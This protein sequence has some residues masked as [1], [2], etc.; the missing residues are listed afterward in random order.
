MDALDN[1]DYCFVPA[2]IDVK[3]AK[4]GLPA[5]IHENYAGLAGCTKHT[6]AGSLAPR[7][8]EEWDYHARIAAEVVGG[9]EELRK[10]PIIRSIAIAIGPMQ[11]PKQACWNILGPAKHG[12]PVQGQAMTMMTANAPS[13][14]AGNISHQYAANLATLAL[15]Q[16]V[17]PGMTFLPMS[18]AGRLSNFG[19]VLETVPD[20]MLSSAARC[21]LIQERL[22]LPV[23]SAPIGTSHSKIPDVQFAYE[24]ALVTMSLVLSG[25]N[26][27]LS[28]LHNFDYF[29]A[30]TF[31]MGNEFAGYMKNMHAAGTVTVEPTDENLAFDALKRAGPKGDLLTD[32]HTIKF[33]KLHY[34]S[35]LADYRSMDMWLRD[36]RSMI[37]NVRNRVK[38]I[39]KHEVPKLP[40]DVDERMQA[41]VE[42]ADNKFKRW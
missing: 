38:E 36:K 17:K 39:D 14:L 21:Q 35:K 26:A 13:T 33:M 15:S 3:T 27:A 5:P 1:V 4:A 31:V 29:S 6:S 7:S 34:T 24:N 25:F 28:V 19:T 37:D 23:S 42:E 20:V 2:V 22:G 12:L 18:T 10:R 9:A 11:F 40:K 32:A 8:L 41:V 16:C 30:E